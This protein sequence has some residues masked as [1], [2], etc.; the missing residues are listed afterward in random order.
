MK[1]STRC[2][3]LPFSESITNQL[4]LGV[5]AIDARVNDAAMLVGVMHS[6][7]EVEP[8]NFTSFGSP[9]SRTPPH[10]KAGPDFG[11]LFS[12]NAQR[13]MCCGGTLVDPLGATLVSAHAGVNHYPLAVQ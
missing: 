13:V 7:H 5:R 1:D 6:L 4:F 9:D 11:L 12:V 3:P 8:F 2:F 10:A